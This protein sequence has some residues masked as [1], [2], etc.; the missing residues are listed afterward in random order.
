VLPRDRIATLGKVIGELNHH[1]ARWE[2]VV[3]TPGGSADISTL[4]AML[5]LLW[6]GQTDRHGAP[7]TPAPVTAEAAEA[8]VHLAVTL[9]QWFNSSAIRRVSM[10]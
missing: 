2:L 3:S 8:A 6:E 1:S 7:I 4:L 10:P 5:R 9:V